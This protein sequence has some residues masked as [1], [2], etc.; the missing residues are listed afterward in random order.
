VSLGWQSDSPRVLTTQGDT[1]LLPR[2]AQAVSVRLNRK[3]RHAGTGAIVGG[4]IGIGISY[5]S[6]H[7]PR[8]ECGPTVAQFGLAAAGALIGAVIRTDQWV[9]VRWPAR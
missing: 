8:T 9:R 3:V 6:C 4:V 1:V 2:D 7:E 5:G